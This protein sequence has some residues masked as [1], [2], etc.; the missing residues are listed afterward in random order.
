[1]RNNPAAGGGALYD[2]GSYA[3]NALNLVHGRPPL[4]VSAWPSTIPASESIV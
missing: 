1:V 3:I 4:R 2:L